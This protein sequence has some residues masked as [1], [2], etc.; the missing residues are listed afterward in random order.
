MI[1]LSIVDLTQYRKSR[2]QK[3]KQKRPRSKSKG[4]V[5]SRGGKLWVDF[6][7]LNERVREPSGLGDSTENRKSLRRQLDLI[8]AEIENG[9]FEFAKRFPHSSKKEYFAELEGRTVTKDPADVIFGDYVEKWWTDMKP[10]MSESQIYDYSSILECHILPRFADVSFSEFMSPVVFK[11]FIAELKGKTNRYKKPLSAKRIQN[12]LIPLRVIV[13]D[14]IDEYGWIDLADPFSN[15]KLPKVRKIRIYPFGFK[16]WRIL[17]GYIMAWYRLYFEFAVQTGLRPS[18]QVALKWSDI[19]GDYIFIERS[20]VKS[21]EKQDLKTQESRRSIE[22]RSSMQKV[23][24]EQSEMA[25]GFNSPYVFVNTFGNPVNQ[26]TLSKQWREAMIKSGLSYRRMYETRHTFA[27]WALGAGEL[28]EWVARTLGHSNTAMV[29][30]TYGRYIR[31]L[32]RQDGSAFERLYS[33]STNKKGNAE[34]CD[35]G[36][37]F[38]HN[39][40]NSG[41]QKKISN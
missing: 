32:T 14:G 23:L 28:P 33:E 12:V 22:I 35:D 26:G 13:R 40:Q 16:E 17:M 19:D 30:K 1:R 27:S 2:K 10:G 18:E 8:I 9:I 29:Y 7:Y 3:P 34:L 5:Y 36:H 25:K 15:L 37:N 38:G 6:R 41:C 11:K 39:R 31:N 20:R 24:E 4:T 21:K